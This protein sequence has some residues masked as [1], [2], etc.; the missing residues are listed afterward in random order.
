MCSSSAYSEI[1]TGTLWTDF[2]SILMLSYKP[3]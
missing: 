1:L 2:G 3:A